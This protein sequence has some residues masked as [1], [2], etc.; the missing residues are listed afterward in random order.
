[1]RLILKLTQRE[2]EKGF[3]SISQNLLGNLYPP[4]TRLDIENAE[5]Q[6]I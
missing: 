5:N 6:K 2:I 1:M 4:I 3:I